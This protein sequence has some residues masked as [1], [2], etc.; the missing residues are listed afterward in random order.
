LT[1]SADLLPRTGVGFEIFDQTKLG[2][3]KKDME[4]NFRR[5][6]EGEL[7]R[8]FQSMPAIEDAKIMVNIPT[9]K[10]YTDEQQE[11]TASIKLF[12]GPGYSRMNAIYP[13]HG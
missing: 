3:T 5:A 1:A 13:S 10:L 8:T 11:P 6:I 4:I 9:D 12:F 2:R 7:M